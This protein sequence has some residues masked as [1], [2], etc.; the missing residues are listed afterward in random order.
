MSENDFKEFSAWLKDA[1]AAAIQDG[2][3]ADEASEIEPGKRA[4]SEMKDPGEI[5][6]S[7]EIKDPREIEAPLEIK[8]PHVEIKDSVQIE[9]PVATSQ[10]QEDPSLQ[11][12]QPFK[13][14]SFSSMSEASSCSQ[15]KPHGSCT[16]LAPRFAVVRL[17]QWC[18]R[19]INQFRPLQ[20]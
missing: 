10:K 9:A 3:K 7:L 20:P 15:C 8:D 2:P 5:K 12:H 19:P 16:V 4:S 13:Q 11:R 18:S 1:A 6:A 14:H 17:H